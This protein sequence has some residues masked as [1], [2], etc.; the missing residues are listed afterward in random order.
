MDILNDYYPLYPINPEREN[1][2][3]SE[4]SDREEYRNI[5]RNSKKKLTFEEWS[6]VYSDDLWYMWCMICEFN[7]VNSLPFFYKNDYA[8]FCHVTYQNS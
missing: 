4:L 7:H 3:D 8:S 5:L 2:S 6:L 1:L